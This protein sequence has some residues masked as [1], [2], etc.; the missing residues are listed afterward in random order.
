[1]GVGAGVGIGVGVGVGVGADCIVLY[2]F[3]GEE[4]LAACRQCSNRGAMPFAHLRVSPPPQM[5]EERLASAAMHGR[6][7]LA[8]WRVL[9]QEGEC[10]RITAHP[11][12]SNGGAILPCVLEVSSTCVEGEE[13]LAACCQRT[14]IEAFDCSLGFWIFFQFLKITA[15]PG[16]S[17][18][19]LPKGKSVLP[20][21]EMQWHS[22][23]CS[24]DAPGHDVVA[25][26]TWLQRQAFCRASRR[27]GAAAAAAPMSPGLTWRRRAHNCRSVKTQRPNVLGHDMVAAH[28]WL[29]RRGFA[30]RRDAAAQQRLQ[31][32]CPQA[33][34]AF[35]DTWVRFDISLLHAQNLTALPKKIG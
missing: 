1:M 34:R 9:W 7:P 22:G 23:G 26:R 13:R 27:S 17:P 6:S 30:R 12:R 18:G 20:G 28:T 4:C 24:A 14:N 5:E 2:V 11:Q 33:W 16:I 25:V 3:Q 19:I 31:R 32:Q 35:G 8:R 15:M 10:E 29:Q 21:V